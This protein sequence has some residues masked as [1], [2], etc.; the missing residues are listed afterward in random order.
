MRVVGDAKSPNFS[1]RV[2]LKHVTPEVPQML[3]DAFGGSLRLEH[4][5]SGRS[6]WSWNATD[7]R[8]VACLRAVLPHLRVK[9]QQALNCLALRELKDQSKIAR[10]AKGRGHMGSAPR[11]AETTAAMEALYAKAKAM[12][13]GAR[14]VA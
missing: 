8:A 6:L 12:N 3:K 4:K 5:P 9:R 11:L 10:V 14:S 7:L 1:E 13:S 2:M